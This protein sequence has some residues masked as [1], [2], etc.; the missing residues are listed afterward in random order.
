M[1]RC[2]ASWSLGAPVPRRGCGAG[3][4]SRQA[5]VDVGPTPIGRPTTAPER[6]VRAAEHFGGGSSYAA[7]EGLDLSWRSRTSNNDR[8]GVGTHRAKGTAKYEEPSVGSHP[9]LCSCQR[10]Y[11]VIVEVP[12]AEFLDGGSGVRRSP[13]RWRRRGPQSTPVFPTPTRGDLVRAWTCSPRGKFRFP[14]SATTDRSAVRK[15]SSPV[16]PVGRTNQRSVSQLPG[17]EH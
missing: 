5:V 11:A 2:S 3:R 10:A 17:E 14:L 13:G 1:L 6:R 7:A 9:L 12:D 4:R 8:A 16:A 15:S